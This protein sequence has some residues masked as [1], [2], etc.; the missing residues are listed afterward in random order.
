[1]LITVMKIN[2]NRKTNIFSIVLLLTVFLFTG[3]LSSCSHDDEDGQEQD[4]TP[5]QSCRIMGDMNEKN[6]DITESDT[7]NTDRLSTVMAYRTV[8][9][10]Q[11][12]TLKVRLITSKDSTV[13]L[14]LYVPDFMDTYTATDNHLYRPQKYRYYIEGNYSGIKTPVT[15]VSSKVGFPADLRFSTIA[16]ISYYTNSANTSAHIRKY[17]YNIK[18]R[19]DGILVNKNNEQDKLRIGLDVDLDTPITVI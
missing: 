10:K 11:S 12:L 8:D 15:Y 1:M 3:L 6:I 19:F 17:R 7:I 4:Y 13:D 5:L 18:G 9:D 16:L 2:N 14:H